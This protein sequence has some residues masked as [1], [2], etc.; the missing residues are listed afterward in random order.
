MAAHGRAP[1]AGARRRHVG[2]RRA[3]P[4]PVAGSA[5]AR[6]ARP[7]AGGTARRPAGRAAGRDSPADRRLAE[8]RGRRTARVSSDSPLGPTVP[9][10]SPS[11]TVAPRSTANEP[12]CT[13]VTES[14]CAVSSESVLPPTG[15][16]PA[17]VTVASTGASTGVPVGA[18]I[19]MPRCCPG[20]LGSAR[21]RRRAGA[22]GPAR[23][24]T[25]RAPRRVRRA[26]RRQQDER[27]RDGISRCLFCKPRPKVPG[28]SAVVKSA[29]SEAR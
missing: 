12:R 1:G 3:R 10:C 24:T 6:A 8:R 16:V 4:A 18:P 20:A 2:S 14:P 5:T 19:E 23:A 27:R 22:R 25:S 28:P 17:K 11:A 15:T 29:Y 21:R 13:S 9:T 26:P 7:A